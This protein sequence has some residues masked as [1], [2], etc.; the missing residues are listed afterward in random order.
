MELDDQEIRILI[1]V[2]LAYLMSITG[3]RM[4]T[5]S[6]TG[7]TQHRLSGLAACHGPASFERCGLN[8]TAISD[9]SADAA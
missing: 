7:E 1:A 8:K 3:T 5:I 4:K 9:P 6:K 2:T